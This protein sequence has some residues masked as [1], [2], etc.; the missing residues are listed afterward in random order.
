MQVKQSIATVTSNFVHYYLIL[1]AD[2][3]Q[4]W[5]NMQVAVAHL[6]VKIV[7]MAL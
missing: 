2:L 3:S 4:K 7:L 1:E 5:L 6:T